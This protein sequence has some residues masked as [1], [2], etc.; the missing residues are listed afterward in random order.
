MTFLFNK[1][2]RGLETLLWKKK[3]IVKKR[4]VVV[5]VSRF[6]EKCVINRLELKNYNV[7]MF[8]WSI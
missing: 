5:G 1:H 3:D 6:L 4:Q 8:F 7:K 2:K